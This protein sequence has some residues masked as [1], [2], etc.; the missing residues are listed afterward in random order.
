MENLR[1]E[2]IAAIACGEKMYRVCYLKDNNWWLPIW[3]ATTYDNFAECDKAA[4]EY[5]KIKHHNV[6]SEYVNMR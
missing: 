5:V 1:T 6:T 2:K 4:L 3:N